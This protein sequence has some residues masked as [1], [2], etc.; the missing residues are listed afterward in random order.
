M[1]LSGKL[2]G[3][4]CVKSFHP[5]EARRQFA[6]LAFAMTLFAAGACKKEDSLV[7]VSLTASPADAALISVSLTVDGV[8]R[9][10]PLSDGLSDS[11][12]T[13]F[14]LYLSS[15]VTGSFTI[16]ASAS[17]GTG[18]GGYVGTSVAPI[19]VTAGA[20]VAANVVLTPGNTCPVDGGGT[21]GSGT[22]GS[23]TGGTPGA[24]PSLAHCTEY[25]H[26]ANP[27]AACVAGDPNTDVEITDVAFSPDGKLVYSAGNDA[28]VKIWTWNGAS[29]TLTAEGH[30][31]DTSGGFAV[32]A[33]S[34]DNTL[35]LA[36]SQNGAATA[37]NV[38]TT[39][40]MAGTLMGLT[41]DVNGVAFAPGSTSK[42]FTIYT[43]DAD[44]NLYI[45]NLTSLSPVSEVVLRTTATPFTLAASPAASDGSY[46]L[47]IG[48]SDGDAS[49]LGVDGQGYV[50]DEV[51][52]TVSTS[53]SGVY[54]SRFSPDGTMLE[55]GTID[56][57]FGIWSVP[58]PSSKAPR[59][60][61]ITL[62]TDS[63]FGGAFDPTSRYLAIAG[64]LSVGT[65]KIGLWTVAT[66]A[67]AATVPTTLFSQRPTAVAFSPDG[68]ALAV[69]EHNCGKI[70]ICAD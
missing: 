14:G 5:T 51:P 58:L 69:G 62:G 65:R 60:P 54:T 22:G 19:T 12:P 44:S 10:Y 25:V 11:S 53:V 46:W 49:L 17:D 3:G 18:C 1:R 9:S 52:F 70:L 64:G 7:V 61:Q 23:G 6:L 27:T 13:T 32:L 45:Y 2:V 20:T 56:G 15:D 67:A 43:A 63:V 38:G 8:T 66:G 34:S 59:A 16:H 35:V 31:L 41:A 42:D 21:G 39:W 68:K 26:N 55:A 33:V 37:W 40:S 29:T 50:G 48:Y 57:S 47:S 4:R 28:R 24:P 30:V 36:G